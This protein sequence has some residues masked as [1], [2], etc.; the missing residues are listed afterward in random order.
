MYLLGAIALSACT[1]LEPY[2]GGEDPD[3]VLGMEGAGIS[4]DEGSVQNPLVDPPVDEKVSIV[5]KLDATVAIPG[6]GFPIRLGFVDKNDPPRVVGGGIRLAGSDEVQWTLLANVKDQKDGDI[7]F[8]Y[9]LP[10]DACEDLANLCHPIETEQFAVTQ[11]PQSGAFAVSE[12][13]PVQVVLQCATCDS[14]SCLDLLP[15]G[16]C[17]A[18]PQPDSCISFY[19]ACFAPGQ[20]EAESDAAETFDAFLGPDGLLW[21]GI[22]TCIQGEAL[23]DN[24]LEA[25]SCDF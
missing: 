2:P 19:E 22:D 5:N 24:A 16:S 25:D 7:E 8:D 6:G 10:N 13:E 12:P 4:G 17:K 11:D 21:G 18:C 1:L 3:R 20:P 15:P 23:C 14:A 9:V